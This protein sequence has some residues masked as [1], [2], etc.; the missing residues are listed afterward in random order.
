MQI[1]SLL[2]DV[3]GQ[4]DEKSKGNL[5]YHCPFCRHRKKKL[6]IQPELGAWACWVCGSKGKT[7][8]SLFKKIGVTDGIMQ[9]YYTLNPQFKKISEKKTHV[10]TISLP[11]DFRPLYEKSNSIYWKNA[12]NYITKKR[13]ITELDLYKYNIGYCESGKYKNML[14]FPN[15]DSHGN[16][17][18]FSTRSFLNTKTFINNSQSR[19]V[20]GFEL[21]LCTSLPLILTEGA[22]DA[23]T[24]R[25]N[26]SPL[27]GKVMSTNLKVFILE[28]DISDVILCLDPDAIN[29]TIQYIKYLNI[30]GVKVYNIEFPDNNDVNSIGYDET[31]KL[32]DN[33]KLLTND[34]IFELEVLN[35]LRSK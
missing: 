7:I 35:K 17:N 5:A 29:N 30:F 24:V 10:E 15:Y 22:I 13:N 16:L 26:A 20:V 19:N 2:D 34:D 1:V 4:H 32:I 9:R 18:F 21:Q 11:K 23:I 3:L 6:E 12:Y 27:Y 14:I 28:N 25:I 33:R 8:Y 31:W